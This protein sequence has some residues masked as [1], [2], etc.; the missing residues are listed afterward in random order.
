VSC[1]RISRIAFVFLALWALSILAFVLPPAVKALPTSVDV[2]VNHA[3]DIRESGLL[4]INDT[5]KLSK[6][7][8]DGELP[9]SFMLGFPYTYQSNLAYAIAYETS[10]PSSRLNL[11]LNSGI[12]RI[13]FYGVN[14][15]LPRA[16]YNFTV[17]F[18]FSGSVSVNVVA[19]DTQF[20]SYNASFPAYPSLPQLA[21]EI[22]VKIIS[23]T[24]L[25]Y[26]SSSF[27]QEG[28]NFTRTTEGSTNIFRHVKS[29]LTEFSDKPAW[30]FASKTGTVQLLDVDEIQR[31]IEMSSN[32]QVTVSD[33][34]RMVNK[35]GELKEV[36]LR[37][38]RESYSIS[39][40]D[41]LG[42]IPDTGLKTE[43][44]GV[45]TDV[46]ITFNLPREEGD[47]VFLQVQY[48]LPWAN[49]VTVGSFGEF[50]ASLS[51]FE[52]TE[53]VIRE[54]AVTVVLPEGATLPAS[55]DSGDLVSVQNAAFLSSF[56]F[57]FQNA[58]PLQDKSFS[59]TYQRQIFW[60]SFRPTVWVGA[61]VLIVG[62]LAGAWHVYQPPKE[63][64]LPTAVIGVRAEDL[65]NFVSHY[66]EKRRLL[67]E[68]ESLETAARKG[69]IPRR[70]Y[71][72]RKMTIDSRLTSLSRD[73]A[74]L[75]DK[76]RT[77]GPRY[78]DLMRQLEVAETEL[79]G[80]EADIDR[81][82]IRYRRGEISAAAYHKLLEDAYRRRDRSQTTIDGVLLRL[83]EETA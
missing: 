25:N 56:A 31:K 27:E 58:T 19:G 34:Y 57:A 47:T 16:V 82:E 61:F 1:L 69:K 39:A 68:T 32:E 51:L 7:T 10:N 42:L 75:R 30:F 21:S 79:Q 53:W 55:L 49:H 59:F 63:A 23:P 74:A 12:G 45:H 9:Q 50:H 71:K 20:A 3:V 2:K 22:S 52:N 78:A 44:A 37:L 60:D 80:V 15:N 66:D 46:T 17:V 70:Q 28:I 13:G 64:P 36:R 24:S 43:Q 6:L 5:V 83:R 73:L 77:A 40:V 41:E 54:L 26:T 38:P 14:V 48:Q 35:A 33:S 62:A 11:D 72:V 18:V 4:I 29:N 76:L 81:T 67:R 65:K 8:D